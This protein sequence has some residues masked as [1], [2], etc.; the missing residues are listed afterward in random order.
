MSL[1]NCCGRHNTCASGIRCDGTEN[2]TAGTVQGFYTLNS[3]IFYLASPFW[4]QTEV[5][6][7]HVWCFLWLS[8]IVSEL[9]SNAV[10][11]L[12]CWLEISRVKSYLLEHLPKHWLTVMLHLLWEKKGKCKN[13]PA[14]QGINSRDIWMLITCLKPICHGFFFSLKRCIFPYAKPWES[15]SLSKLQSH[16]L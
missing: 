9:V 2:C 6:G 10:L 12:A 8:I 7:W 3:F 4:S 13:R 15:P 1:C 14:K 5:S 16:T 11:P